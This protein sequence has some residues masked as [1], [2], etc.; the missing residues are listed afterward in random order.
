[1][2]AVFAGSPESSSSRYITGTLV[3]AII[4]P[5]PYVR[6]FNHL[7]YRIGLNRFDSGKPDVLDFKKL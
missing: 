2:S 5:F 6:T 4:V 1:V 3:I 7:R